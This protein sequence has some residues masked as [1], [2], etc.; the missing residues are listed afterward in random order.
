VSPAGGAVGLR[1][2]Y[3]RSGS[4]DALLDAYGISVGDIVRAAK[5]AMG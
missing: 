2:Q 1:D 3:P 5:K 4:A